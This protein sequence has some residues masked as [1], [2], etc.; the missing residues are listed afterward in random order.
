[1]SLVLSKVSRFFL[2]LWRACGSRL[3]WSLII[4]I[5]S[6]QAVFI[7]LTGRFSMAFDEYY[8]LALIKLYAVTWL[9]WQIQQP[10]GPATMGVVEENSSY[11]YHYLMSFPYRIIE[12]FTHDQTV[13]II[14]LR[15]IDVAI[16][17]AGLYVF[18]KLLLMAGASRSAAQVILFVVTLVPMTAFLAGQMTYDSLFFSATAL[19]LLL[20]LRCLQMLTKKQIP[21]LAL[22]LSTGAVLVFSS[23]IKYP[24][25]PMSLAIVLVCVVFVVWRWRREPEFYRRVIQTWKSTLTSPDTILAGLALIV[26]LVFFG[27]SDGRNIIV[28]HTPSP[29]CA[30]VLG[31][32]RCLGYDPWRRDYHYVQQ[33][34]YEQVTTEDKIGYP[35]W[36]VSQMMR[37]SYFSV[38]PREVGY[39]AGDPL[40]TSFFIGKVIATISI[41]AIVLG[42]KRLWRK[43]IAQQL[44]L[45]TTLI[46]IGVLFAQNFSDYIRTGIPVAIHGRYIIQLLPILGF[47]AY[48][49]FTPLPVKLKHYKTTI[50]A[51]LLILIIG[52]FY[53]GGIMVYIIRSYDSWIW[54]YAVELLQHIRAILWPWIAK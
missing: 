47:L 41:I 6:F 11:L 20:T 53:G 38:G 21:S 35:G 54:P 10:D 32:E 43:G 48:S 28:Y 37:E 26:G 25:L 15:F 9:P 45:T 2:A 5:F 51:L 33:K 42:I 17:I 19:T 12:L 30:A 40:P 31:D 34:L 13:Q 16:V 29:N 8:H 4:G 44:F 23:L 14:L 52:A 36:W 22:V 1:M 50:L 27:F 7:A 3:A 39:P 46:Y 18:R 49:A 24:F